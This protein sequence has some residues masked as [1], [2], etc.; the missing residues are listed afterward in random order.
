MVTAP[1]EKV[2]AITPSSKG[3][4]QVSGTSYAAAY[5]TGFAALLLSQNPEMSPAE[6][7]QILQESSQ[8]L[9]EAGYDT[10]YGYGLINVS[11]GLLLCE[12]D[13]E[14]AAMK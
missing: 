7:R 3:F 6:F 13:R 8:D 10:A 2:Y 12:L 4:V 14:K 9:G 5:V 11:R 1:G